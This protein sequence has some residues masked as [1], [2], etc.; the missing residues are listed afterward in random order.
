MRKTSFYFGLLIVCG[1]VVALSFFVFSKNY[2]FNALLRRNAWGENG[3]KLRELMR[4]D[5]LTEP[6]LPSS[7]PSAPQKMQSEVV[8]PKPLRVVKPAPAPAVV[9]TPFGIFIGTNLERIQNNLPVL[10]KNI[11]LDA[12]ASKKLQDM[13]LRQFFAHQSPDGGGAGDLAKDAG[14]E[15]INIGENLA[16]GDFESDAELVQA[17]MD[18]LGHR[19][20]ILGTRYTEIGIAVGKGIFEGRDTWLA[21][22]IFARPLSACPVPDELLQESIEEKKQRIEDLSALA[23]IKKAELDAISKNERERYN[24]KVEEYNA[25]VI[26]LNALV[27]EV[28]TLIEK[29]N[30]QVSIFNACVAAPAS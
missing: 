24:A 26:E 1:A 21:V 9:L 4:Q 6:F 20:N 2:D 29:Y 30:G 25:I 10:Q 3:K 5:V 11:L 8:A 18:S 13:F 22:Q 15:Y 28:K 23:E 17:W 7:A 16:L 19:E 12:A 27:E 14:Y